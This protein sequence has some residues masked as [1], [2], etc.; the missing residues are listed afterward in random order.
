M[1]TKSDS[2]K[3]EGFAREKPVS[4]VGQQSDER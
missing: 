1:K 2:R 3:G 4:K